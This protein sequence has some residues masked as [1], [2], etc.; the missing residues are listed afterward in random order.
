MLGVINAITFASLLQSPTQGRAWAWTVTTSF[1]ILS[2]YYGAVLAGVQGVGY[3]AVHR[4]RAIST[5][6]AALAFIPALAAIA[7]EAGR[8]QTFSQPGQGWI[9]LLTPLDLPH[10]ISFVA[11]SP[12]LGFAA[13]CWIALAILAH[14]R[15]QG[16]LFSPPKSS[17]S[18]LWM[19]VVCSGLS[20][21]ISIG[22][23]LI[24]PMFIE[25][26]L[27]AFVP[28]LLFGLALLGRW[29]DRSWRVAPACLVATFLAASVSWAPT[30]P[31]GENAYNFETAS[32]ALMKARPHY[33]IFF[34]D[35]PIRPDDRTMRE[36]GRFFFARAGQSIPV[37]PVR[38]APGQDPIATMDSA[39]QPVGS[40]IL[41]FDGLGATAVHRPS[42]V[43][44]KELAWGCHDFGEG[45]PGF[46]AC[47]GG[48]G[49]ARW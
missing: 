4:R 25:R 48:V 45:R 41:W 10:V 9:P 16:R 30:A 7:L 43:R 49:S 47:D 26:Y 39:A 35:H 20:A 28:G 22:L 18:L 23:G 33:L 12:L 15:S 21:L 42:S 29:F 13:A 1:L 5:W 37:I 17:E 40:A 32:A 8:L 46:V 19:V 31:L 44:E 24:R 3:L 38:L 34:W 6:L 36:I 27:T 11:G 14:F 2:H